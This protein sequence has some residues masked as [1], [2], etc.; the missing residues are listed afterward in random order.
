[1]AAAEFVAAAETGKQP[2]FKINAYNGGPINVSAFWGALAVIDLSGLKAHSER[3]PIL[4]QIPAAVRWLSLEPLLGPVHLTH[5][6]AEGAG[7]A[8]WCQINA[9]AGRQT[10]MGRPCPDVPKLDW[11]VVGGESGPGARPCHTGWIYNIVRDASLYS[12]PVFVKQLGAKPEIEAPSGG[13][14]QPFPVTDK[15]GGDPAEWPEYLRVRQMPKG[16]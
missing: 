13:W 12:V 7:H 2:T 11:L 6:D 5:L 8:E 16:R 3:I 15:K 10:D 4:L 9:L 14:N 1:M